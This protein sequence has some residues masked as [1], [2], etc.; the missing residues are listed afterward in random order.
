MATLLLSAGDASGDL[1]AAEF[2]R[3]FAERNPGTRLVGLG[4]AAM[5]AAGVERVAHQDD[6]AV[7][8]LFELL[9]GLAG[10]ARAWRAMGAAAERERPDLVVLVDSGGFNLPLARRIKRRLGTPILYYVAPQVWAWRCRRRFTSLGDSASSTCCT[11]PPARP[12]SVAI[13]N[14]SRAWIVSRHG[15][16]PPSPVKPGPFP[17]PRARAW[18]SATSQ[19]FSRE[20]LGFLREV[21]H[22]STNGAPD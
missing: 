7:G 13:R 19:H 14:S 21:N 10:V 12:I 9:G 16:I 6:L 17:Y 3:V 20:R 22:G 8:G 15:L 4:G 1:H 5:D 11:S 2:A 18:A